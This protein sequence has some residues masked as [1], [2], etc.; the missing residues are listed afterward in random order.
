[1]G[2]LRSVQFLSFFRLTRD[3]RVSAMVSRLPERQDQYMWPP[4]D[5]PSHGY[6][7]G[8][9]EPSSVAAHSTRA[10]R[11][12]HRMW[13]QAVANRS[14]LC[15]WIRDSLTRAQRVAAMVPRLLERQAPYMWPPLDQ[16]S[17]GFK[18]LDLVPDGSRWFQ[19]VPDGARQIRRL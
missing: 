13:C 5:R 4:S 6:K 15:A 12:S 1:M 11:G 10:V 19:M 16:P 14:D 9:T 7:C 3:Q 8:P 17:L 2:T 18:F